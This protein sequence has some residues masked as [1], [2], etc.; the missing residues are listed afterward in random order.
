[1]STASELTDKFGH[2]QKTGDKDIIRPGV[3]KQLESKRGGKSGLAA[4]LNCFDCSVM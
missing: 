1:M 2:S 4:S 3:T